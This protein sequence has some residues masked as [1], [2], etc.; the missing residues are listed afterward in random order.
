MPPNFKEVPVKNQGR[1]EKKPE[2]PTLRI[3]PSGNCSIN[4]SL[5]DAA[6][7][8]F[9]SVCFEVDDVT[10]DFRFRLGQGHKRKLTGKTFIIPET[11]AIEIR[12][13]YFGKTTLRS[14][15]FRME[16]VEGYWV[17]VAGSDR[18]FKLTSE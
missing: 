6:G 7:Y 8:N 5:Y 1:R 14:I 3:S 4:Q 2:S 9:Q 18:K 13:R 16:N 11:L 10:L 17:P 12:Y 15:Y